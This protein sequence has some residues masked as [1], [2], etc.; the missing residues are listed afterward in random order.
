MFH[1]SRRNL[2]RWF[3]LSMG[4]ILVIF[5]GLL[6]VRE[7]RDRL[8]AF[9]QDLLNTSQVMA[10]GVEEDVYQGQRR[11]DLESVPLLGSDALLLE[12]DLVFARWYTS[13]KQLLQF[14]GA[15]PQNQLTDASGFTTLQ[16]PLSGE[17][18][19]QLT[20][21]V[22]R[23]EMLLGYLQVAASLTPVEAPLRQFQLFLVVGVPVTLGI[24]ALAGWFLGGIAMQ[25][26]RQSY[27]Q[28]QR[29]TADASHELRAPLAAIISNAQV[30]LMEPVEPD[31]QSTRLQSISD[32]AESMSVI[33]SHLLLLAR[34]E[35][36]LPPEAM[37]CND[38][39]RLLHPVIENYTRQAATQGLRLVSDLPNV[40]VWVNAEPDLLR[41]AVGNLLSN[42]C[43]Y[44]PAGGKVEM[45]V[46]R[47]SRW[48]LIQIKDTGIGIAPNDLPRIF[49]R[50]YRVDQVRSRHTRGFGLGLAITRQVVEAH[51]GQVSVTSILKQGSTFTIRLPIPAH[52]A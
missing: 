13:E 18:L 41:Q 7:A 34:H 21:P 6:Y 33:V 30:G 20:L 52:S 44:T 26:I 28:L 48:V 45:K 35:G 23:E 15:I 14:T 38:L 19:R 29:F 27:Q 51:G 25:P 36:Q 5:A 43:C 10:S 47:Q 12:T 37:Q 22:Y 42:A 3:T 32:V 24:I 4:S 49:E 40:S 2:A 9:D 31:E 50:F 46:I 16:N 17:Q 39:V 11:I 8:S 1:R